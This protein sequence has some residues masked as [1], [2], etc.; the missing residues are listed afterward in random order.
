MFRRLWKKFA[1]I[2]A[3]LLAVAG[4]GA[5]VAYASI[6]APDGTINGC[7]KNSTGMLITIDSSASCPSGYTALNWSQTGPQGPA[8]AT[9]ATGPQGP[10]GP[11]TGGSS[12]LDLTY[13]TATGAP[14][15]SV[16]VSCPT[17]HPYLYGGGGYVDGGSALPGYPGNLGSP[18][19]P[20]SESGT[21]SW[22]VPDPSGQ[23]SP[24]TAYAIC[25]K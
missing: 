16:T 14:Y 24:V 20:G 4:L 17:D 8:G 23:S 10:A 6:P 1:L 22:T 13:V 3:G 12:G 21:Q 7:Y 19:S 15:Y 2:L 5:G 11:S 9:G 18:A 25:G